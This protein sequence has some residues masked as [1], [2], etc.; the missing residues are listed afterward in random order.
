MYEIYKSNNCINL[1]DSNTP[2][3]IEN[4]YFNHCHNDSENIVHSNNNY[5]NLEN[6][7][8]NEK[9]EKLNFKCFIIYLY[10]FGYWLLY[11]SMILS[12]IVYLN[13]SL[14]YSLKD[15]TGYYIIPEIYY[16]ILYNIS[17]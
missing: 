12:I 5:N 15:S 1:E 14:G 3:I 7:I 8:L 4:E 11:N 10:N 16:A 17:Y 2:N 13:L 9:S 6:I